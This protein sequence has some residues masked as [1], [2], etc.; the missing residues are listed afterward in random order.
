[1][2]HRIL[3][4]FACCLLSI[5]S[6]ADTAVDCIADFESAQQVYVLSSADSQLNCIR[7]KHSLAFFATATAPLNCDGEDEWHLE[8]KAIGGQ[9]GMC[10]VRLHGSAGEGCGTEKIIRQLDASDAAKWRN[11]LSKECNK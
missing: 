5:S 10:S 2:V 4:L 1:M 8:A 9:T 11:F 3:G 7:E 6:F